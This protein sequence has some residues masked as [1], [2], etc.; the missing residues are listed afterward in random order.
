MTYEEWVAANP[1]EAQAR[2]Q[3]E[4]VNAQNAVAA[5]RQRIADIDAIAD[6]F[7]NDTVTAAKYG[8]TACTAQEMAYRAALAAAKTGRKFLEAAL[9]DSEETDGITPATAVPEDN[10]SHGM[11]GEELKAA[12][13]AAARAMLGKDGK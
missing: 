4:Q 5:E 12:G 13:A 2:A 11:T 10:D 8:D 1:D 6:Q 7:D 9:E 3:A